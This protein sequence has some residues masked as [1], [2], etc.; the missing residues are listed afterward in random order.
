[1]LVN[2]FNGLVNL[3]QVGAQVQPTRGGERGTRTEP[4]SRVVVAGRDDE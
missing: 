3:L 2:E 1:M 4:W